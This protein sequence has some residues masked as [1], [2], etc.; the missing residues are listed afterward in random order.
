[1]RYALI[2]LLMLAVLASGQF[3]RGVAP[4]GKNESNI[5]YSWDGMDYEL[6]EGNVGYASYTTTTSA[7]TD[8]VKVL[9]RTAGD[10]AEIWLRLSAQNRKAGNAGIM[11]ATVLYNPAMQRAAVTAADTVSIRSL[12]TG[13]LMD[14]PINRTFTVAAA[15]NTTLSQIGMFAPGDPLTI[16]PLRALPSANDSIGW[17]FLVVPNDSLIVT[18]EILHIQ[19]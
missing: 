12:T 15:K 16:G 19:R 3:W 4:I 17:G 2:A 9:L 10:H 1:M 14:N 11:Y 5:L 7:T 8:T 13:A 6:Q 18:W